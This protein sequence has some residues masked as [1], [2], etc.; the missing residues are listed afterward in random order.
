MI[1]ILVINDEVDLLEACS[2]VLG[3][4]G[5]EVRTATKV[6]EALDAIHRWTPDL[7]L[8]DWVLTDGNGDQVLRQLHEGPSSSIP[9]IVMSALPGIQSR[10]LDLGAREFSP[11]PFDA[12]RLLSIVA[13]TLPKKDGVSAAH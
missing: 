4:E 8:L 9:V 7:V 5:Y 13:A 3:S 12:V 6:G 2:L 10:A 11:K 1:R